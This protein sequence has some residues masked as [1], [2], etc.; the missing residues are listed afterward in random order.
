MVGRVKIK[1]ST[2]LFSGYLSILLMENIE[3]ER[4]VGLLKTTK[5]EGK[6]GLE[7]VLIPSAVS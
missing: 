2:F 6:L 4:R 5:Q 3:P 1:G 7:K